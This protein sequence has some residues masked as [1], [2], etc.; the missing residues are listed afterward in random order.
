MELE[1]RILSIL[2]LNKQ[3]EI[4]IHDVLLEKQQEIDQLKD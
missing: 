4:K 3:K 2:D 1:N